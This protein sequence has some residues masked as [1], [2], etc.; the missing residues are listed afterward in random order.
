LGESLHGVMASHATRASEHLIVQLPA[1]TQQARRR[2]GASREPAGIASA[3]GHRAGASFIEWMRHHA[4]RAF[5]L[6]FVKGPLLRS[7][8]DSHVPHP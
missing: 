3:H 7:A 5:R 1:T 2:A 4:T 6:A 8:L